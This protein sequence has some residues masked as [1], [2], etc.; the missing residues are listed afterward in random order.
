MLASFP[1]PVPRDFSKA[2]KEVIEWT[3]EVVFAWKGLR[4]R[5]TAGS[6]H[7][8]GRT[9]AGQHQRI[10]IPGSEERPS[11][12]SKDGK[13]ETGMTCASER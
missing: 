12:G 4:G 13:A 6:A 5:H 9:R 10:R 2:K 11:C 3:I 7:G 8:G 1:L